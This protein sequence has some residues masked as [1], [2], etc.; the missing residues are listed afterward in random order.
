MKY[1]NC[2]GV[3]G[4]ATA[5]ITG[6]TSG[7]GFAFA[8]ELAK[9]KY[10]LILTGTKND[11]YNVADNLHEKYK[12]QT[13]VFIERIDSEKQI[14]TLIDF[15][16]GEDINILINNAG[17]GIRGSFF[18]NN[19]DD[20]LKM[21]NLHNIL[22][23]RLT[24]YLGKKMVVQDSGIIVNISSDSAYL[25]IPGNAVYSGT[26]AFI[27]QFT[28]CLALDLRAKESKVK[29]ICVCPGMTKSKFHERMGSEQT[30]ARHS[31]F[32]KFV[33]AEVVVQKTFKALQR[34]ENIV[35][36]GGLNTRLQRNIYTLFRK[37]YYKVVIRMFS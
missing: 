13:K 21:V 5:L 7:I 19:I 26:K 3:N 10:N 37:T 25:P 2:K 8:E 24:Q 6:A 18:E 35:I 33:P 27:K 14:N 15:I 12:V 22:L 30:N 31:V 36:T 28:E 17:Y 16:S 20:Y 29:V 23:L 1:S 32:L 9:Q 34:G 11:L 4:M